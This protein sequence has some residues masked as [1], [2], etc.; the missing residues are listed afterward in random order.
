MREA[1]TPR[2]RGEAADVME[3]QIERDEYAAHTQDVAEGTTASSAPASSHTSP[4]VFFADLM[5]R[6]DVR[7]FLKRLAD[8]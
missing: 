8:R 1:I 6:A 3:E 2:R 4:E 7:A 5:A